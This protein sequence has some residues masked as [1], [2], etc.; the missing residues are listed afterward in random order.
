MNPVF[1]IA[2]WGTLFIATHLILSSS[3]VRPRL[4]AILGAQPFRGVYSL[5][6]IGTLVMLIITFA[7][8]KHAGPMLWYLRDIGAVRALTFILMLAALI[9]LAG[10]FVTPNPGG[11]GAPH[12]A[13][14][15]G[16]L[17]ITRHPSFVAFIL[18]GLAHM[19]MNGWLGDLFFFGTFVVLGGAGGIHQDGRKL[20]ELGEP[21]RRLVAETSFVPGVAIIEGRQ[22]LGAVDIPWAGIGIGLALMIV[23]V[24]L[25]PYLFGGHPLQ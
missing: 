18:F 14:V 17:K 9:F 20:R 24:V 22:R 4:V 10:A 19:L 21:Y 13:R 25:H 8:H 2:L 15:R 7:H 6:A 23:L 12:E 16:M 1:A 5:V 11:I 3:R